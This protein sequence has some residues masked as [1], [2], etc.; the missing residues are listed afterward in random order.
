MSD[1][2]AMLNSVMLS[3]EYEAISIFMSQDRG[4]VVNIRRAGGGWQTDQMQDGL[5]SEHLMG[6]LLSV[7]APQE[8]ALDDILGDL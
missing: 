5:P 3:G 2:T 7:S 4:P 6:M 8:D 1:L